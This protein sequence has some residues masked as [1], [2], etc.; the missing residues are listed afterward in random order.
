MGNV[1]FTIQYEIKP[2]SRNDYLVSIKELKSLVAADGLQSYGVF[3]DKTNKN[4]FTEVY[5]FSDKESF[6][7]YDDASNERLNILLEK[8]EALKVPKSTKTST[9]FGI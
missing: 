8:I 9:Q 2:E 7:N 1:L 6:D 3:E 5:L 4:R